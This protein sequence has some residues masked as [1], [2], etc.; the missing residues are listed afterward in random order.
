MK[1]FV[2]LLFVA[3]AV[4]FPSGKS[5]PDP[6]PEMQPELKKEQQNDLLAIEGNPKGDNK[7]TD[8]E[9]AKRDIYIEFPGESSYSYYY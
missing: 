2:C 3:A 4:A 9:R 5:E 7:E 1:V 8:A 6:H